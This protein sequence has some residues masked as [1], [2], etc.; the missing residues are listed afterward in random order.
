M[1][2]TEHDP[3]HLAALLDDASLPGGAALTRVQD[4]VVDLT[5]TGKGTSRR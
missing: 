4:E 1:S 3:G 5:D 2:A